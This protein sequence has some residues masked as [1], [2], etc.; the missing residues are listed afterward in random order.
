MATKQ[1]TARMK[2]SYYFETLDTAH[3]DRV[4]ST[5]LV[6]L[7]TQPR[8]ET[9]FPAEAFVP[10]GEHLSVTITNLSLAGLRLEG[11]KRTARRP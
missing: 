11:S 7:R 6:D 3:D 1:P 10:N 8:F 5:V 9:A 2:G 4:K